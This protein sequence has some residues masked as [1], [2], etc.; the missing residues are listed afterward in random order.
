MAQ[1]GDVICQKWQADGKCEPILAVKWLQLAKP[2]GQKVSFCTEILV[3][4]RRRV[5]RLLG[6]AERILQQGDVA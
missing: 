6:D 5:Q 4:R 1:N 3:A 2:E